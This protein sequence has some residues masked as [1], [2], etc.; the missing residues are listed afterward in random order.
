MDCFDVYN[1]ICSA[2]PR[3]LSASPGRFGP[4]CNVIVCKI[5]LAPTVRYIDPL[6]DLRLL[7]RLSF[8]WVGMLSI[9]LPR[10]RNPLIL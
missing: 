7:G 2:G 4:E 8:S 5:R 3:Y 6:V 1:Y 9:D 10:C